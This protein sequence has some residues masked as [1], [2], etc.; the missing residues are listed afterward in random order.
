MTS[1]L[2]P[3]KQQKLEL[4]TLLDMKIDINIVSMI[5]LGT[6]YLSEKIGFLTKYELS[7]KK[8]TNVLTQTLSRKVKLLYDFQAYVFF[9][10]LG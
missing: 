3:D 10:S 9:I 1:N 5:L 8:I 2:V 4:I 7:P 6:L